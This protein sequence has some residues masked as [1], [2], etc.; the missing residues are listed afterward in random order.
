MATSQTHLSSDSKIVATKDT[1]GDD[2][3]DEDPRDERRCRE[4]HPERVR[5]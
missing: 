2:E 1:D 5:E 4:E 3:P